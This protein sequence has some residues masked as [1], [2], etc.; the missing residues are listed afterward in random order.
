MKKSMPITFGLLMALCASGVAHA[1]PSENTGALG[2]VQR[3]ESHGRHHLARQSSSTI[4]VVSGHLRRPQAL[5]PIVVTAGLTPQSVAQSLSSISVINRKTIEREQPT[6]L[7]QLLRGL[8]GVN[9]ADNGGIGT[10]TSLYIRGAPAAGTMLLID[11]IRLRSASVGTPA[12][13]Y[14]DPMLFQRAELVRGPRSSLYGADASGGVLQLFTLQ[15]QR[16][17]AHPRFSLGYGSHATRRGSASLSGREG[18][19]YYSFAASAMD[20]HGT[21]VQPHTPNLYYRNVSSLGSIRHD[22]SNG[23][24]VGV[25]NLRAKGHNLNAYGGGKSDYIQQVSGIY[26]EIPITDNWRSRL[27]LSESKDRLSTFA[28]YGNSAINTRTQTARWQ[29]TVDVGPHQWISGAEYSEDRMTGSEEYAHTHR[30]NKA[31]FTEGLLNFDPLSLQGSLRYDDNEAY[32]HKVTGGVAAGLKLSSVYTL[33]AS[34]GTA[35]RA[36]TFNDLYWPAGFGY[37]GNANLKPEKSHTTELGLHAAHR[38]WYWDLALYQSHYRDLIAT[39]SAPGNPYLSMPMNINRANIRGA[40]LSAGANWA[41]WH[42]TGALTLN[43]PK[44]PTTGKRLPRRASQTARVDID[45][46]IAQGWSVGGTLNVQGKSYNDAGN[47]QRIGGF[48]T[49]DARVGWHF[50]PQWRAHVSLDNLTNRHYETV[51][52]YYEPKRTVMLDISFTP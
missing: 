23:A 31:L 49:V 5:N 38:Q 46:D 11:G 19:T 4:P 42:I 29:N 45:R 33:R 32:G 34:Y 37:Q 41:R 1:Q 28:D 9:I 44:D 2:K 24:K 18:N 39:G 14:L 36:P 20:S 52:G 40:E 26:G 27:T 22:F 25:M 6:S 16:E 50:A 13:Q 21:K 8:P 12:L 17:G 3:P 35:F 43:N 47:Q 7:A 15:D 51:L 10:N 30:Y 48:T